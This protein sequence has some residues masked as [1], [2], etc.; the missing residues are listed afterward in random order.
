MRMHGLGDDVPMRSVPIPVAHG[1]KHGPRVE[2]PC[3]EAEL[4]SKIK[5]LVDYMHGLGLLE[6]GTFTFPD[7]DTWEADTE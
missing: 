4:A 5:Y 6:D 2:T 7:G 1:A 3:R